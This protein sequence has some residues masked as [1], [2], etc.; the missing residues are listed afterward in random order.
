[1]VLC[2]MCI[3]VL[4]EVPPT[5]PGLQARRKDTCALSGISVGIDTGKLVVVWSAQG[6]PSG[7]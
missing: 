4:H 2:V 3:Q 1:M 7:A 6:V 5:A